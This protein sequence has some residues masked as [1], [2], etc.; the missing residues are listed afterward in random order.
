MLILASNSPRRRELLALLGIPFTVHSVAVDET[1]SPGEHP[2]AYVERLARC[3]AKQAAAQ[4]RGKGFILAADTTVAIADIVGE[5]QILGKPQEPQDAER[6]L[7]YLRGRTHFV[8]SGLALLQQ[9]GDR[10][11]TDVC[12]SAVPI[13]DFSDEEMQAYIS[14]GDPFDKAGAYAIQHEGFH[15]VEN[16]SGCFA[17]V[18]GLSLCHLVRLFD[19]AGIRIE[20][21]PAF[22]C[23]QSLGFPCSL[24]IGS[25]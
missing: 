18:M 12:V 22:Q 9:P 13:R 11:W 20:N 5:W 15:P 3:K 16:F 23:L 21:Q 10:S 19:Q 2:A 17:N 7:R 6:M 4:W 25:P 14:S 8:F 1:P 24:G